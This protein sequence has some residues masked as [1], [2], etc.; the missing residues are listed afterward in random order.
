MIKH[1]ENFFLYNFG[2][3]ERSVWTE[4]LEI[5]LRSRFAVFMIRDSDNKVYD[6][7]LVWL[8]GKE[9]EITSAFLKYYKY[10]NG[11]SC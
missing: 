6:A 1:D 11:Q 5:N 10:Y 4:K 9:M 7:C 8:D 2:V 3:H